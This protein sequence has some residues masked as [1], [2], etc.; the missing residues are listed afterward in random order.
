MSVVWW[1][2]EEQYVNNKSKIISV[3]FTPSP[4]CTSYQRSTGIGVCT[5]TDDA[6]GRSGLT[7]ARGTQQ[8]APTMWWAWWRHSSRHHRICHPIELI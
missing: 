2:I 4:T 7:A 3:S 5:G 1:S 8:R 6:G